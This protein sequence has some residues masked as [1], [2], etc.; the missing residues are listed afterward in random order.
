MINAGPARVVAAPDPAG[1]GRG[2]AAADEVQQ[3]ADRAM[4][5][6][7]RLVLVGATALTGA[8]LWAAV[9]A[10]VET[11]EQ[12]LSRFRDSAELVALNRSLGVPTAVGPRL[13]A[14]LAAADRAHRLTDGRFDPRVLLELERLGEHG[15]D[16]GREPAVPFG[17]HHGRPVA[18]RP[19]P[20][21]VRVETPV[22]L[23]G[24]GKGLALRW[25]ARRFGT[26]DG[27]YLLEAGGDIVARGPSPDGPAWHVAIED[28]LGGGDPPAIVSVTNGA[29]MTSSIA[30]RRWRAPDGTL[31][32]HLVDPRSHE[33]ADGGL[34]SVTVA[35]PDPAWGE[36]WTK[37][38]FVE[39]ALGI[40]TL[41]RRHGLAAWWIDASG[42]LG[43]T[44]AARER[45]LWVRDEVGR[46]ATA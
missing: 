33:P 43:M 1:G 20:R 38:L 16:V 13:Y 26:F 35:G 34:L 45:T 2:A 4:G 14:A 37:G 46:V 7:L 23:G 21:L 42:R 36:V 3:F 8:R 44:P 11:T 5:S 27:G 19:R 31:V 41:A 12:A 10:D 22:D 25:A 30:V 24:I 15:A 32:H 28:P 18:R 39:G 9:R 40:A 6:P 17:G 29:V